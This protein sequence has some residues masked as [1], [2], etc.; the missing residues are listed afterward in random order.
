VLSEQAVDA[1]LDKL[2]SRGQQT[3]TTEDYDALLGVVE[4]WAHLAEVAATKSASIREIRRLLGLAEPR[5]RGSKSSG[6]ESSET[7]GEAETTEKPDEDGDEETVESGS[8]PEPKAPKE[9]PNRHD[10][11]RRNADAFGELV[12]AHHEHTSLSSGD[13]CPDCMRGRVYKYRPSVFTTVSGRSPL[14]ATRHTVDSL[15]CNLCKAVFKAPLPEA[16]EA[17]GVSGRTLY[18][19]SAVAMVCIY[20]CFGGLP[21][22]RQENLQRALGVPVPD[23][24]IWDM[25][26]RQADVLRPIRRHLLSR[27]ANAKL[28]HGDDTGATILDTRTQVHPNR[29]TGKPVVRTGCH[30]TCV[31]AVS[32]DDHAAVLFFTGI[33]HTGEV[34]DLILA[35]RDATLPPP[36]FMGDCIASNTV[37]S[38]VVLYAACNAHAVRRFKEL[39]ESYPEHT[40]YVLE[41]YRSIF[42]HD[43]VC[44]EEGF[45]PEERRDY[46]Q[47]HSRPLLREITEYGEDLFEARAVEP[48]SDLGGAFEYVIS[49][50]RRLSAFA[51][52][53]HAPLDNNWCERTIRI[54]VRLRETSHSFRNAIG[55]GVA[56]VILTVGGTAMASGINLFHYF[57]AAQRHADDVR[58]NPQ[59][60]V[61][62]RYQARLAHLTGSDPPATGPPEL[63]GAELQPPAKEPPSLNPT[64]GP[65]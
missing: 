56:D 14:V 47:E 32:D 9:K 52:H 20:R 36:I 12:H 13:H 37:S 8:S 54:C 57:V 48:N 41:R 43:D 19:Y 29:R 51:R 61:P 49:N 45:T 35:N 11:G 59:E 24:S 63:Q 28:F 40:N 38:A 4:T 62:W 33:Q 6:D 7:L 17:D 23:A 53:P 3:F 30:T 46:H 55:A 15:Q 16:L 39:T 31:I 5:R 26:E 18:S 60:W 64:P 10:H 22:H 34:M 25:C 1:L 2:R 50:E 44:K 42:E 58:A 21:M 65:P 27:G